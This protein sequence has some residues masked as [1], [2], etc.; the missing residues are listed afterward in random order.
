[1]AVSMHYIR[2]LSLGPR[3]EVVAARHKRKIEAELL[4]L[5]FSCFPRREGPKTHVNRIVDVVPFRCLFRPFD[6][7][8]LLWCEH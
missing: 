2:T 5:L 6:L 8:Q 4:E 3:N 1:M 7:S